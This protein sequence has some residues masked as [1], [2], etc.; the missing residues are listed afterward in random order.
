MKARLKIYWDKKNIFYIWKC[1]FYSTRAQAQFYYGSLFNFGRRDIQYRDIN[2][3]DTQYIAIKYNNKSA[4][5]AL[6]V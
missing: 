4:K 2:H 6:Y 3:I 5:L 1:L